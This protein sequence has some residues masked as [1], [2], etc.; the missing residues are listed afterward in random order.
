M[1]ATWVSLAHSPV[2][3]VGLRSSMRDNDMS[4]GGKSQGLKYA[5]AGRMRV[6]TQ[7]L[8]ALFTYEE[9]Y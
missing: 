6:Q 3:S 8:I 5:A 4:I 2:I 1:F 9:K 7:V